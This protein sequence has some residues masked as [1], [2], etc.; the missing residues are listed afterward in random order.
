MSEPLYF[1]LKA[2]INPVS[3]RLDNAI[4]MLLRQETGFLTMV[5]D[6]RYIK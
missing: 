6:I 5:Q 3:Y 1:S 2:K 4:F